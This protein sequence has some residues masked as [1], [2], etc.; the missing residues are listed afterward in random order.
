MK[1]QAEGD[2]LRCHWLWA[3]PRPSQALAQTSNC[4]QQRRPGSAAAAA[5]ARPGCI[6]GAPRA[7][8]TPTGRGLSWRW[9]YCAQ[10]PRHTEWPSSAQP[11]PGALVPLPA[12]HTQTP[13]SAMSLTPRSISFH[14]ILEGQQTPILASQAVPDRRR[15][16]VGVIGCCFKAICGGGPTLAA[17]TACAA[18][19][20]ALST[21]C[22]SAST[23]LSGSS[24]S[25]TQVCHH[26]HSSLDFQ[27][28]LRPPL[29]PASPIPKVLQ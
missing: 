13:L 24:C 1:L 16:G 21:C 28:H 23:L 29:K 25:D 12:A 26:T 4:P 7:P 5:W 3:C 6:P 22:H 11:L 17:S 14:C 2:Y 19:W 9:P 10:A 27:R 20:R 8:P 15:G 18:S